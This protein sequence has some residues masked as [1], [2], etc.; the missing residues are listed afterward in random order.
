MYLK[1]GSKSTTTWE[2]HQADSVYVPDGS[3]PLPAPM[4]TYH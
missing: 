1:G 3:K 4:W 2:V